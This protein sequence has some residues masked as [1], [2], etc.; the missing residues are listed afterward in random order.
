VQTSA[1]SYTLATGLE[2]LTGLSGS[3]QALTGNTDANAIAG[4]SGADTLDGGD[5]ADTLDGGA[6][7]DSLV[8]GIGD[9]VY[10]VDNP[11]DQISDAAGSRDQVQTSL[12]S[13]TLG[14]GL[15]Q[16]VGL[17]TEGQVLTGNG[18]AN[19][20]QGGAGN[21]TLEGGAG[22]DMLVGGDGDDVYLIDDALEDIDDSS[23]VDEVRTALHQYSLFGLGVEKLTGLGLVGQILTGGSG[24]DTIT[25]GSGDD[26]IGGGQG[27]DSMAGG[28]GDDLYSVDNAGDQVSDTSGVDQVYTTLASY[29]LTTGIE[30]LVGESGLGQAL[31]GNAD[32]NTI[33][34]AS[35]RGND[36]LDGGAGADSLV[37]WAGND[38]YV[39]D[40]A[41]DQISDTQGL[42]E[43]RTTLASYALGAGLEKLTGLSA[44]G[45]ALTGNA[46]R[47]TIAGG[48]GD[49]TL[50]G[51]ANS[52]DLAGGA[53]NDVYLIDSS[54]DLITDVSG[55]DEVRTTLAKYTLAAKLEKL[56]GL[57]AIGQSLTGNTA[58]N[59]IVGGSGADT[60]D[61]G[62]GAD[63]L[64]GGA[65]TDT[66]TYAASGTGVVVDLVL[67]T[68]SGGLGS[69]LLSQI[70]NV[71]GSKK[72]DGLTGDGGANNL[73][74]G[75]GNDTLEG[76]GGNDLLSGGGGTDTASYAHAGAAVTVDLSLTAAQNTK[77][78]GSDTLDM[79][80]NLIGSA[81]ADRL[82]G[83][84]AANRL[85]GGEGNDT[86]IGAAGRDALTGG[87]GDDVFRFL[88]L[89]DST[90]KL[91][92]LIADLGAADRIDLS[93]IDA[94]AG[95]AGDQAFHQVAKFTHAAGELV[96]GYNADRDMTTLQLDVDGDA[97]A[98]MTITIA[99][100]HADFAGFML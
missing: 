80:E 50:D 55:V 8:G 28:D 42:D 95:T 73:L 96:V 47:N 14:A 44:T 67:G 81:F 36:T 72:A 94:D 10:V 52:D 90:K 33:I 86:L 61:G 27:A 91:A 23:G 77:G 41:G 31:T 40:N 60:L 20:I 88:A 35:G 100:D 99:G 9:D 15:E 25:G 11:G 6:G 30:K 54:G 84:D 18:D 7:A 49:D 17:S 19:T 63:S 98:D 76:G 4:G 79:I 38:V 70:E 78:A 66:V 74:G 64:V 75:G 26:S 1:G 92:D 51:G 46:D 97:R 29:T 59:T 57:A 5:G 56:T 34:A 39:I 69:D 83:S 87:D 43:V 89:S 37:G 62:L 3:G 93:A 48:S 45:Q 16:L 12:A 65:G 58:A 53:G 32:A 82:T 71:I 68:A 21:D 24:D 22:W 85:D 2:R 13:Y